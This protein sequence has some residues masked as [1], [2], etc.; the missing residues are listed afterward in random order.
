MCKAKS[1]EFTV[2]SH[3]VFRH[4]VDTQ[5]WIYFTVNFKRQANLV[6]Y[7]NAE[8]RYRSIKICLH[9]SFSHMLNLSAL[10]RAFA[11]LR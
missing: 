6:W 9:T 4:P 7:F 2:P 8:H 10:L 3:K 1:V 5:P 11:P